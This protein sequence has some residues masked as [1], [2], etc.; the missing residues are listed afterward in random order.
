MIFDGGP[1]D[2][3]RRW[4]WSGRKVWRGLDFFVEL[5]LYAVCLPRLFVGACSGGSEPDAE[6]SFTVGVGF[7]DYMNDRGFSAQVSW[8]F[9]RRWVRFIPQRLWYG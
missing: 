7:G 8:E 1:W 9:G 3:I 4:G 5:N 2:R 6:H